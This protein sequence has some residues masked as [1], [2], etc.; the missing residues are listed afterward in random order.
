MNPAHTSSPGAR[1]TGGGGDAA[2]ADCSW[3]ANLRTQHRDPDAL[4]LAVARVLFAEFG[5]SKGDFNQLP[6]ER[7][8]HWIDRA[9]MRLAGG[10][11]A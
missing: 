9:I 3:I 8:F 10:V 4:S 5:R 6:I 2:P 1:Q 11:S 7:K